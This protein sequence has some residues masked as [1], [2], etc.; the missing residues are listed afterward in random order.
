[1]KT[2]RRLAIGAALL[3]TAA[4]Y[5]QEGGPP[6]PPP[7]GGGMAGAG[8]FGGGGFGWGH[9]AKVITGAP[10]SADLS[11]QSVQ[12]L[13]DGNTITRSTRGHV[14]RDSQGR[15]YTQE[16]VAGGPFAQDGPVTI[17]FISDPVAG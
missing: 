5:A 1:M 10:Y 17:T 6:L 12:T 14:A 9:R 13:A 11:N 8:P 16:T 3:M 7:P 15:T 2:Q 4:L